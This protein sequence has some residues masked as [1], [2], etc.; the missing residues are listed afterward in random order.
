MYFPC[1][2]NSPLLSLPIKKAPFVHT[3]AQSSR[4]T[5]LNSPPPPPSV[6]SPHSS[7]S[8]P[9]PTLSP[10]SHTPYALPPTS[11]SPTPHSLQLRTIHQFFISSDYDSNAHKYNVF[12]S[13][14]P[15]PFLIKP[16]LHNPTSPPPLLS[17][18]NSQIV[19]ANIVSKGTRCAISKTCVQC[20]Y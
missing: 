3:T 17:S 4:H 9:F 6:T 13:S 5:P 20:K 19:C 8:T 15:P 11:S 12:G 1:S 18:L 14:L 7:T 10:P 16:N 2:S